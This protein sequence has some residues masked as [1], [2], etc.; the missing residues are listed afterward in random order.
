M[1]RKN[2]AMALLALFIGLIFISSY[3]TLSNLNPGSQQQSQSAAKATVP[4]TVYGFAFANAT[5]TGYNNTMTIV[6]SCNNSDAAAVAANVSQVVS[7]L[8]TNNSIYNSYS[9]GN[10]TLVEAGTLNTESIYKVFSTELNSTALSCITFSASAVIALPAVLNVYVINRTYELAVPA[11]LRTSSVPATL[12]PNMT[13]IVPV[14]VS[15]LVTNNGT[16][17][18][19]NVTETK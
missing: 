13:G 15:T 7:R 9:L 8:E 18:S 1:N 14:R 5:I 11:S 6:T 4:Q 3:F 16:I 17:Y 10:E 19:L 2:A 12:Y